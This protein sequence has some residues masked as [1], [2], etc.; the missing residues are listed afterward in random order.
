L[1]G[2][3][4]VMRPE[5][6]LYRRMLG[7]AY[8]AL[9]AP[10]Q[11]MHELAGTLAAEGRADVERGSGMLARAI[12]VLFRFPPAARDIPI[13]VDFALRDGREIW[14]RDFDGRSFTSTQEEGRGRFDRLLCERF[15]P[16][17]FGLALVC[18]GG[19]LNLLA[20]AWSVFGIPMPRAL[21]PHVTAYE[22]VEDGRFR[23][24]VEIKLPLIGLIVRYRGWLVPSR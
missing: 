18:E 21:V 2:V 10:I 11:A 3:R 22:N 7:D 5:T 24:Y 23:F 14:R 15:G 6:P 13:R 1:S 16:F 8:A 4:A 20:R 17:A 12:G 9:P 19:R